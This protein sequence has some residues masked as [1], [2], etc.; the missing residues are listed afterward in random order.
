[1]WILLQI[2][3]TWFVYYKLQ[4][5]IVTA[6]EQWKKGNAIIASFFFL[7]IITQCQGSLN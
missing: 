2:K 5:K 1:M 7:I 4:V 3:N 6:V